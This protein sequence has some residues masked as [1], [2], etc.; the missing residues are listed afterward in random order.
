MLTPESRGKRAGEANTCLLYRRESPQQER[1]HALRLVEAARRGHGKGKVDGLWTKLA[2]IDPRLVPWGALRHSGT[3]SLHGTVGT[4]A[5]GVTVQSTPRRVDSLG[6]HQAPGSMPIPPSLLY[7]ILLLPDPFHS[8]SA[9][10][11]Q[12]KTHMHLR[13]IHAVLIN[14]TYSEA[15]WRAT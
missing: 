6:Q 5:K 7:L 14:D 10:N 1:L 12:N 4:V 3:E 13:R 11:K 15:G 9:M 2:V 8:V